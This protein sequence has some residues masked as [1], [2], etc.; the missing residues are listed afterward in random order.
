MLMKIN[1]AQRRERQADKQDGKSGEKAHQ[2][3][4]FSLVAFFLF[5][6]DSLYFALRVFFLCYANSPIS[7]L[8]CCNTSKKSAR[9]GFVSCVQF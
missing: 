9:A 6:F 7:L 2:I 5:S 4:G 1:T 3:S 8:A